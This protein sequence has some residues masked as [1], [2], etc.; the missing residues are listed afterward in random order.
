MGGEGRGFGGL[1]R[2]W[3]DGLVGGLVSFFGR[4]FGSTKSL[5]FF[6]TQSFI[7]LLLGSNL[8]TVVALS[9]LIPSFVGGCEE[10]TA[11]GVT[12]GTAVV[13]FADSVVAS[14]AASVGCCF[15][16]LAAFL[17]RRRACFSS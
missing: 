11:E 7:G 6:L 16:F 17:A 9:I 15:P 5:F 10:G 1:C 14:G 4:F 12:A 3:G 13:G 2:G 8:Y